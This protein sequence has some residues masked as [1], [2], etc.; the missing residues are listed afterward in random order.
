MHKNLRIRLTRSLAILLA[1]FAGRS[2]RETPQPSP[3]ATSSLGTTKQALVTTAQQWFEAN[4]PGVNPIAIA[5][6]QAQITGNWVVAPFADSLNVFASVGKQ[7][8]R[9]VV[10][11]AIAGA[12]TSRLVEVVLP[13]PA[14]QGQVAGE[15]A[16]A[17]VRPYSLTIHLLQYLG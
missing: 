1:F 11:Q 2:V 10:V 7:G 4:Q 14:P 5:W 9:Y 15:L 8:Y 16:L 6:S 17:A 12:C 13:Q 3:I